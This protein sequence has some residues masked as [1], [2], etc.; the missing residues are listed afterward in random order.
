MCQY[1]GTGSLLAAGDVGGAVVVWDTQ[2]LSLVTSVRLDDK[3][4]ITSLTWNKD[5][6]LIYATDQVRDLLRL[7]LVCTI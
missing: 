4:G 7:E 6:T 3:A 1:N 5:N 2:S